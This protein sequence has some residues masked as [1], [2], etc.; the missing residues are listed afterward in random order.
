MEDIELAKLGYTNA[1]MNGA[2]R[3]ASRVSQ[4]SV[5]PGDPFELE[6]FIT[7]YG[8]ISG[9]KIVCFISS[10]V[11]D[12][13]ESKFYAGVKM[14][15]N[16][17]TNKTLIEW[18]GSEYAFKDVGT[19]YLMPGIPIEN[20]EERITFFDVANNTNFISTER[21]LENAPLDYKLK[22]KKNAHPGTQY[23]VF[24]L[25]YFNGAEWVCAEEKITFKINNKFEQYSTS[26]S[27]LAALA[28]IVTIFHDGIYPMLDYFHDVGKYINSIRKN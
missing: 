9:A 2:Y 17:E 25:T 6:Q 26:L 22:I 13:D 1:H 8:D 3:L 7:G 4:S 20:S 21:K 11:F 5:N 15:P 18:G 23:I 12:V 19:S 24:Y 14:T 16:I 10:D 28:L 27:V